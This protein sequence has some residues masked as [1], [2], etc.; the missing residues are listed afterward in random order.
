MC[1]TLSDTRPLYRTSWCAFCTFGLRTEWLRLY[2]EYPN[3]WVRVGALGP[4]QV[5][6]LGVWLRT[7]DLVERSGVE[8]PLAQL[9]RE[10][11]PEAEVAWQILWAN[12]T[13]RFAT[14]QWFVTDLGLGTW[15]TR[16]LRLALGRHVLHLSSRTVSNGITELV[17]LLERTPV[18]TVWGQ[19]EVSP[20]RP[21]RVTRRGLASPSPTALAHAMRLLFMGER[22]DS[23]RLSEP[24][25]WPWVVY[26]CERDEALV[27]LCSQRHAWLRIDEDSVHCCISREALANVRLF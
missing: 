16:E 2:L 11:W 21:R 19:G 9:F 18:G 4:R 12:V 27:L 15:T 20:G 1:W 26:G 5:Q 10:S 14:A 7:C 6:S 8:L 13:F 25:L 24:V 17:G 23:L 3:D 22:R